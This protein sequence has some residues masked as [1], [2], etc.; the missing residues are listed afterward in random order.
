MSKT[1]NGKKKKKSATSRQKRNVTEVIIESENKGAKKIIQT[2]DII[3]QVN[4]LDWGDLSE[5]EALL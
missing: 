5:F 3:K 2:A 1:G 4:K